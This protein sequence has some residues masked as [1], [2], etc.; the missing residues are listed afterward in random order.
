MLMVDGLI[1][2][3]RSGFRLRFGHRFKVDGRH[4]Q[5]NTGQTVIA[6]V[7]VADMLVKAGSGVSAATKE[8]SKGALGRVVLELLERLLATTV[9]RPPT[10][11]FKSLQR[12]AAKPQRK[13][14]VASDVVCG[15]A[16]V[17]TVTTLVLLA[18]GIV[19]VIA[20]AEKVTSAVV[21]RLGGSD[22]AGPYRK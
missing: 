4:L 1:Y 14:R 17:V 11:L 16:P 22:L 5:Q 21:G 7:Q 8:I 19:W 6:N 20:A 12:V 15:T 10:L 2:L 3:L 18:A 9:L 13:V